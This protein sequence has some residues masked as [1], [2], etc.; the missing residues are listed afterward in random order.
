VIH[1]T[2]LEFTKNERAYVKLLGTTIKTYMNNIQTFENLSEISTGDGNVMEIFSNTKQLYS[3]HKQFLEGL[4]TQ[5]QTYPNKITIG[6]DIK[7]FT[8]KLKAYNY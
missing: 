4:Q 5:I 2:L 8:P 1:S 3:M 7:A 6:E